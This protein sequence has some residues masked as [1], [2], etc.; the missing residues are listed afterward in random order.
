MKK[1]LYVILAVSIA[2]NL[3]GCERNASV[4][5]EI[6]ASPVMEENIT[7]K[8]QERI[9]LQDN[10]YSFVTRTINTDND[11]KNI[12]GIAYIPQG[13]GEKLPTVVYAHGFNSTSES[14]A[15]Y[16]MYLAKQMCIRDRYRYHQG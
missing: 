1:I 3:T 12:Y 11:G 5:E 9:N 6:Q 7:E 2:I 14:G 4:E 8:V 15:A 16:A 10:N 13:A